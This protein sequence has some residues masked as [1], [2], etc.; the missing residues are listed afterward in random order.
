MKTIRKLIQDERGII[1]SV[2]ILLV[3]LITGIGLIAGL[4]FLRDGFSQELADT[5]L[6]INNLNQGYQI[7]G[8]SAGTNFTQGST[9]DD[10]EDANDGNDTANQAPP[11]LDLDGNVSSGGE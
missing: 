10:A 7:G 8:T 2:E 6:A 5:G 4:A 1:V 9:F 3:V 11:G